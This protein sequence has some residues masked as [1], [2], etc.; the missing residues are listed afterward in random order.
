MKSVLFSLLVFSVMLVV[1]GVVTV[2]ASAFFRTSPS[3]HQEILDRHNQCIVD[4]RGLASA[5]EYCDVM[6]YGRVVR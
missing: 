3:A 6:V 5:K 2:I 4:N 1:T